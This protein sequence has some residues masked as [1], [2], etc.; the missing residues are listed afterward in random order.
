MLVATTAALTAM[1]I[2]L[3][4]GALADRDTD[5]ATELHGYE[6][7]GQRDYNAWLGK[8][9]CKRLSTGLDVDPKESAAFLVG[10]LAGSTSTEQVWQFMGAAVRIYCPEH[11]AKLTA[12][13]GDSN[14]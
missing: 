8:I 12:M 7:Y 4:P 11:T 9:T 5:F 6:I 2:T 13:A 14:G 1:A 10:N 3:A